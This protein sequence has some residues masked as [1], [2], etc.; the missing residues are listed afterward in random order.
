MRRHGRSPDRY[1]AAF[2]TTTPS[3]T[4][5]YRTQNPTAKPRSS[6]VA[7]SCCKIPGRKAIATPFAAKFCCTISGCTP[8]RKVPVLPAVILPNPD[9]FPTLTGHKIRPQSS[10]PPGRHS[11]R[12]GRFPNPHRAQN[13]TAKPRPS[14][15]AKSRPQIP[16]CKVPGRKIPGHTPLPQIPGCN[17][18]SGSPLPQ[19]PGGSRSP[20]PRVLAP[21]GQPANRRSPWGRRSC[22]RS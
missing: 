1:P 11:A 14:P 9:A 15:A 7:P 21:G 17:V 13:P 12:P 10:G 19:I 5:P 16:C 20:G 22:I 18:P 2:P 8:C 6:P 4:G 3:F